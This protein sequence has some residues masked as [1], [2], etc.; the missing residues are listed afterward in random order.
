MDFWQLFQI[1]MTT[2]H[3]KV[4]RTIIIHNPMYL[5]L[6]FCVQ[7]GRMHDCRSVSF[8]YFSRLLFQISGRGACKKYHKK[9]VHGARSRSPLSKWYDISLSLTFLSQSID[10]VLPNQYDGQNKW[11]ERKGNN[12]HVQI[13]YLQT[14]RSVM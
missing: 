11:F 4:I 3:V 2:R 8:F 9:K 13:D 10:D 5:V 6:L 1:I 14:L 12:C 7:E